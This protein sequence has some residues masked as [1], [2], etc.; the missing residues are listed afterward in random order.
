VGAVSV[1]LGVGRGV[2]FGP[3]L[4]RKPV[5]AGRGRPG[6][7][8]VRATR[9]LKSS[10]LIRVTVMKWE[11]KSETTVAVEVRGWGWGKHGPWGSGLICVIGVV[12]ER[13]DV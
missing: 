13:R 12:P 5:S 8:G 3:V 7:S 2:E 9:V 1:S 6:Q 11:K 10:T 4:R